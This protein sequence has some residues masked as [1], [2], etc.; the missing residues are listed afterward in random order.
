MNMLYRLLYR[1]VSI[2]KNNA[3]VYSIATLKSDQG[4]PQLPDF[5]MT[6]TQLLCARPIWKPFC[7]I[8]SLLVSL[9]L[10]FLVC[11]IRQV[12]TREKRENRETERDT[13][14]ERE[15]EGGREGGRGA[16]ER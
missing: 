10:S 13:H 9:M 7:V 14:T 11:E 1:G 5:T 15:R 12:L 3:P 2:L 4:M 8:S 16:G 6:R